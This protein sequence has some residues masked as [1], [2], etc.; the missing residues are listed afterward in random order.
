MKQ[1]LFFIAIIVLI[2]VISSIATSIVLESQFNIR[3]VTEPRSDNPDYG[4]F[5][6][7]G[8]RY[9]QTYTTTQVNIGNGLH[10]HK[11]DIRSP[12]NE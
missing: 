4:Y 12:K 3:F 7:N 6:V 1:K 9:L 8:K 11:I 10:Y 5:E 2:S